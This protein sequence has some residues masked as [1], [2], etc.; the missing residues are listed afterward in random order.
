MLGHAHEGHRNLGGA[1]IVL[2]AGVDALQ[3]SDAAR[4]LVHH[5]GAALSDYLLLLDILVRGVGNG[6]ASASAAVEAVVGICDGRGGGDRDD[7]SE[8]YGSAC[9]VQTLAFDYDRFY[10][11]H[12]VGPE[13][14]ERAELGLRDAVLDQVLFL[15]GIA[16]A[17]DN[18]A[19]DLAFDVGGVYGLPDIVG[20][21]YLQ[22]LVCRLV[23]F[24]EDADLGGIAVGHMALG[25][26]QVRSERIRLRQVF[27]IEITAFKLVQTII[28]QSFLQFHRRP[29]C[30]FTRDGRVSGARRCSAVR[31]VG[32]IGFLFDH[33]IA[34]KAG[35]IADHLL[36]DSTQSLSQTGSCA[37]DDDLAVLDLEADSSVVGKSHSDTCVLHST[38]YSDMGVFVELVLYRQ[39]RFHQACGFVHYLAVGK[40][41]ARPDGIAEPDLPVG[42]SDFIGHVVEDAL[43]SKAA[44]GYSEAPEGTCGRIVCIVGIAVNFKIL[45]V[46]WTRGMS[47]GPLENR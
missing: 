7:L 27:C 34:V 4:V 41:L 44:L 2:G 11:R 29:S 23:G 17:H 24:L 6:Q 35:D 40:A 3:T 36:H 15:Q 31:G 8:S 37:V 26:G 19:F 1:E 12:F 25:V 39:K 5:K 30:G 46:V 20:G 13:E 47:T 32:G 38:G 42:E 45:I 14:P 28:S 43:H 9:H 16:H 18:S 22:Y 33:Q 21:D 10:L